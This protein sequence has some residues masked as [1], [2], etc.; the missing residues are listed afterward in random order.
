[1]NGNMAGIVEIDK[2]GRIV[3]PKKLREALHLLPGTQ[4]KVEQIGD[5]FHL[6]PVH[7]EAR[8][9][10][11]RGTA[12]IFSADSEATVNLTQEMVNTILDKGRMERERR[13]L[14]VDGD[15]EGMTEAAQ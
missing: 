8:V 12:L 2:S 7:R 9:Q 6:G 1:M 14:G 3:V 10:I 5:G 13:I 4:L 11:V 15:S